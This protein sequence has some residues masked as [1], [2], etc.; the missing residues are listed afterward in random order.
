M[1][2]YSNPR[3]E[4]ALTGARQKGYP[5]ADRLPAPART[6]PKPATVEKQSGPFYDLGFCFWLQANFDYIIANYPRWHEEVTRR[7]EQLSLGSADFESEDA[8][9]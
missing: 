6:E 4:G 5:Y 9:E 2:R 7:G 8:T 3:I 1:F